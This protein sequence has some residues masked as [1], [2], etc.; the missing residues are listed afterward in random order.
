MTNVLDSMLTP[1]TEIPKPVVKLFLCTILSCK[2]G[3]SRGTVANF[4]NGKYA[5]SNPDEI[6]ELEYQIKMGHPHIYVR[7]GEETVDYD[8]NDPMAE[9]RKK[10]FEEFKA[11]EKA[12]IDSQVDGRDMGEYTQA[13]LKTGNTT[14]IQP[15]TIGSGKS[16]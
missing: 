3:F 10:F 11:S 7:K 9:L 5:T 14:D 4:V 16:K 15:V 6:A 13:R 1:V 8:V 2:Y 12:R